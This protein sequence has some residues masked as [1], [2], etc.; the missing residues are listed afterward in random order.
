[1][2]AAYLNAAA[3]VFALVVAF[4]VSPAAVVS[5]DLDSCIN[6]GIYHSIVDIMW[7]T[8]C[9]YLNLICVCVYFLSQLRI[10]IMENCQL[11][12]IVGS[13]AHTYIMILAAK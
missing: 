10:D 5:N 1:M 8:L 12:L 9:V 7:R 11:G 4:V 3:V 13:I 6:T 2:I